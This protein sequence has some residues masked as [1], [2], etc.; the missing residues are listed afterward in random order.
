MP[1]HVCVDAVITI[2]KLA[3]FRL[4]RKQKLVYVRV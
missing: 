4:F 2:P 3:R 1:P